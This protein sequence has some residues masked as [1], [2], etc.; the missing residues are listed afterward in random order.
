M[1]YTFGTGKDLVSAG[2]NHYNE[3]FVGRSPDAWSGNRYTGSEVGEDDS[4]T[5]DIFSGG[6]DALGAGYDGDGSDNG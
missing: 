4:E 6:G 5:V 1:P 3:Q 2:I